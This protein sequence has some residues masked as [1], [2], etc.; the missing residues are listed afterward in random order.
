MGRRRAS[1]A[2]RSSGTDAVRGVDDD[3]GVVVVVDVGHDRFSYQVP[4]VRG[5][6]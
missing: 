2:C 5:V 6:E 4:E 3:L 1:R